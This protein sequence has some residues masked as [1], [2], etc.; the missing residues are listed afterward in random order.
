MSIALAL[1]VVGIAGASPGIEPLEAMRSAWS[2]VDSYCVDFVMTLHSDAD[3]AISTGERCWD[4]RGVLRTETQVEGGSILDIRSERE[5]WYRSPEQAKV[6]HV[7]ADQSI[8]WTGGQVGQGLG[9]LVALL[10]SPRLQR[11]EDVEL[12]G[13][14]YWHF[15][16]ETQ[17]G[18]EAVILADQAIRLPSAL[19]IYRD[20]QPVMSVVYRHLSLDPFLPEGFF[21]IQPGPHEELVEVELSRRHSKRDVMRALRDW[22]LQ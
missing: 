19:E 9:E 8:P 15:E 3:S 22:R 5:L 10:E 18:V 4:R 12:G 21:S 17:G 20:G 1:G 14:V 13:R 2:E 7:R 11:Q 16:I 6:L